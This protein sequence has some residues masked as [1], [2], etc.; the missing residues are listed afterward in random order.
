M[1]TDSRGPQMTHMSELECVNE[2]KGVGFR[3]TF[4]LNLIHT[5]HAMS[6]GSYARS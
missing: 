5:S 4:P 6:V 3:T 1:L 2:S